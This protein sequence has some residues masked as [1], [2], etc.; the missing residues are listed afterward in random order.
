MTTRIHI[1]RE[2]FEFLHYKLEESPPKKKNDN[3]F[4]FKNDNP[5][6]Y[7]I[8]KFYW[9]LGLL[10][11]P[12]TNNLRVR[13]INK[14]TFIPLASKLLKYW[15][16]NDYKVY[17]NY[18]A[19]HGFIYT[20]PDYTLGECK[21]YHLWVEKTI[22]SDK[23]YETPFTLFTY[24]FQTNT[25]ITLLKPINSVASK[26]LKNKK[27]YEIV[28]IELSKKSIIYKK[29][30]KD[31][32]RQL[33]R[34]R[35]YEPFI[36]KMYNHLKKNLKVRYEDAMDYCE[37]FLETNLEELNN[38][39]RL[40][41]MNEEELA[42]EKK[43]IKNKYLHRV[44]NIRNIHFWKK[45][46]SLKFKRASTNKRL[47]TN[48]TTIAQDLRP[49]IVGYEDMSYLDLS[50]SQPVLLNILL[51][52][53]YSRACESLRNEM[54]RFYMETISGNWYEELCE[55]FICDR[56][57]AKNNWMLI[58]YSK[59]NTCKNFK[60]K[61]AKR[62]P[63]IRKIMDEIK[64]NNH[65]RF[66]VKLQRIESEVFIDE[67]CKELVD[68]GIIP[69]SIHDGVLIPREKE[70]ETYQIMTE[71]LVRHL[72]C[73]PVISINNVKR[74]DERNNKEYLI[75]CFKKQFS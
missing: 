52:K 67:I 2:T 25:N 3:L 27:I 62:Y 41:I 56:D 58:A 18:L 15:L 66:A 57:T 35:K 28:E 63:Q 16:G 11:N 29:I 51:K 38:E 20:K 4:N 19:V 45:Y 6:N 22:E 49:Y 37:D 17:I 46:K 9:V 13:E 34:I 48:L 68:R 71:I 65:S 72:G 8:D 44:A 70:E 54:L 23:E 32:E 60:N 7:K 73:V 5:F 12:K 40:G 47:N 10:T 33:G 30:E 69:F 21:H 24:C 74:K 55:I 75:E 50:N 39:F 31:Y 43:T 42:S 59:N 14:F 1:P 36:K 61:F 26:V 64:L 53:Y